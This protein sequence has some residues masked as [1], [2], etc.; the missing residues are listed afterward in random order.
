MR[1]PRLLHVLEATTAGVRRYV[2]QLL[3]KKP[4]DWDVSVACPVIRQ[5]HFG[6]MAFV[7]DLKRLGVPMYALPL[8]R[9]IGPADAAAAF[10]LLGIVRRG[11]FDLI[12][13]HSSKA[14]FIGRWVGRAAG[15]PV[16]HTPNGLYFLGQKG[17]QRRFY[18]A[19]ERLTGQITSKMVAVSEGERQVMLQ[20]RLT[21]PDRIHLIE[22]G[23]DAAWVREQAKTADISSVRQA[24]G[25]NGPGP[26]I[27]GVGRMVEQKDPLSFVYAAQEIMQAV[28]EARFVWCGDGEL[29]PA[30]E[31]LARTLNVPLCVTGHLENV[32]AVM[33]LFDVFVL[34]SS[35]EGL[36]FALLEAMALDVPVVATDVVGTRD[37]LQ[38]G[39]TG[40][41]VAPGDKAGLAQAVCDVLTQPVETEWRVTLARRL[42]ETRFSA[43]R[44]AAAHHDLYASILWYH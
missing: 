26:L 20:Y 30:V 41:L 40:W 37:V 29:R 36:P 32:W 3:K 44:M 31:N 7:D 27:G 34:L 23:V 14:G 5:A 1:P 8:R 39:V 43:D 10:A 18:W 22:N 15:V 33:R 21:S 25:L 19:L 16:V 28:P 17:F 4:G 2:T 42:V 35:Y 6:D 38:D 24:L 13:T 12:H 11:R 9:S